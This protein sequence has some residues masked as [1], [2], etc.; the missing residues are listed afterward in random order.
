MPERLQNIDS[1]RVARKILRN[2]DLEAL[3][4]GLE[5]AK[6][7]VGGRLLRIARTVNPG[8]FCRAE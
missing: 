8:T 2:K 5:S 3:I 1:Q 7:E 6:A 4:F